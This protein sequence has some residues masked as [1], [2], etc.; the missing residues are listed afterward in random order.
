M[1]I[2][3]PQCGTK[4]KFDEKK[5]EIDGIWARC[6]RCQKVFFHK[7]PSPAPFIEESPS[8]VVIEE[9]QILHQAINEEG[10]EQPD[11]HSPDAAEGE[12]DYK[13]SEKDEA[14]HYPRRK[15]RNL[16]TPGKLAAY[17]TILVLV[18]GGV[19]LSIFPEV[20]NHLLAKTPLGRYF[21][22][23]VDGNPNGSGID[24][25]NVQERF[26]ENRMV[27][28]VMVIQGF[29]VNKNSHPVSKIK[30]RAKLLDATGEFSAESEAYCGVLLSEEELTNLTEK[31]I[32]GELGNPL[33]KNVPTPTFPRRGISLS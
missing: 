27:G 30:V 21:G 33:G 26:V 1:I 2:A 11:K 13:W 14:S 22:I 20:A 8:A 5:M 9:P 7:K 10:E 23:Q 18:L 32:R 6:S 28:P 16:W 12:F 17:V 4:F 25:L 19:Y 15:I 31:E 29:A 24:L 3:C